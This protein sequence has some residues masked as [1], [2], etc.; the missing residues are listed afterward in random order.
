MHCI[1]ILGAVINVFDAL[2]RFLTN[3]KKMVQVICAGV[4]KTGTK[5]LASA[6]RILG[7]NEVYE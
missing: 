6:L 3:K 1:L 7:Y 5:S 2:F 4:P